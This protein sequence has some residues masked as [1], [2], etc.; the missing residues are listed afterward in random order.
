MNPGPRWPRPCC[1]KSAHK[2]S[3]QFDICGAREHLKCLMMTVEPATSA[4]ENH[5]LQCHGCRAQ[6][7]TPTGT[8]KGYEWPC[9]YYYEFW[10]YPWDMIRTLARPRSVARSLASAN[11]RGLSVLLIPPSRIR[12]P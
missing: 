2:E 7:S 8:P 1:G 6:T 11:C 5:E 3:V 9:S 4:K 12:Q 10:L